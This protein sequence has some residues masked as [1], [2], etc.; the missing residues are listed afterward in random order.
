VAIGGINADRLPSLFAENIHN[1]C[2]ISAV[3]KALNPS[4]AIQ[5]LMK[6]KL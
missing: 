5:Q 1:F 4:V 6:N 3:N 2:V